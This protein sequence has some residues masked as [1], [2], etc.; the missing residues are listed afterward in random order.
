M[1]DLAGRSILVVGGTAGI[2]L[3]TVRA[4]AARGADVTVAGRRHD[5][6]RD[7]AAEVAGL[8]I[9]CDV[10]AEEECTA[11]V[12]AVLERFGRLDAVVYAAGISPLAELTAAGSVLWQDVLGTVLVGAAQT[13]RAAIPPLLEHD[14]RFVVLSSTMVG[15]P[16]PGMVPYACARAGLEELV[17]G[18]RAEVPALRVTRLV[19]GPT[20]TGFEAHFPPEEFASYVTRWRAAGL[21]A[22]RRSLTPGEVAEAI[23]VSLTT[24]GRLDEL[25]VQPYAERTE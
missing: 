17:R 24:T 15:R 11:A 5:L 8:G 2:G 21:L 13:L 1:N 6:A 18:V 7:L 22:G 23:V 10:R 20:R 16:W 14:G 4:V 9:R 19:V 3:A 25:S 12:G